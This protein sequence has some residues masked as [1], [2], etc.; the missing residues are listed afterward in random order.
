MLISYLANFNP[1]FCYEHFQNKPKN[2]LLKY[3]MDLKVLL[4]LIIPTYR[5]LMN[6]SVLGASSDG[7]ADYS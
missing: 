2:M 6:I 7:I 4:N 5:I 3:G 1:T